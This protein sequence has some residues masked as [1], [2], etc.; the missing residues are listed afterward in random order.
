MCAIV[1]RFSSSQL[2]CLT[3]VILLHVCLFLHLSKLEV[4]DEGKGLAAAGA[5]EAAAAVAYVE[6]EEAAEPT[7]KV[8]ANGGKEEPAA[9]EDRR[10]SENFLESMFTL[11]K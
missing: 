11:L 8:G 9:D 4:W 2:K 5:V 7:G 6:K 3:K 1:A 10:E